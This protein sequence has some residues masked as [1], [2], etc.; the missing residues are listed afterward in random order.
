M[1]SV[2]R[3]WQGLFPK[4]KR[5]DKL[6][7][8]KVPFDRNTQRP[9]VSGFFGTAR[10]Q[11]AEA[12]VVWKITSDGLKKVEADGQEDGEEEGKKK[13]KMEMK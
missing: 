6:G 2:G 7:G 10:L 5:I 9:T 8:E 1:G 11:R 4:T 13:N 3:G 12:S